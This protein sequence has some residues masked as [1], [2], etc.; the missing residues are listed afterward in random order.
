VPLTLDGR[1]RNLTSVKIRHV[2][3]VAILSGFLMPPGA[4]AQYITASQRLIVEGNRLFSAGTHAQDKFKAA[5]AAKNLTLAGSY[6]TASMA[7]YLAA[8]RKWKEARATTVDTSH[9]VSDPCV[10]IRAMIQSLPKQQKSDV[11]LMAQRLGMN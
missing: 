1:R 8:C 4:R 5:L 10:Q 2:A 7:N 3:L 6:E 9:S 11:K